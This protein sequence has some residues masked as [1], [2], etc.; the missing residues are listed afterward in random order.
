MT[1]HVM[2]L[3]AA[4]VLARILTQHEEGV[5]SIVL[6]LAIFAF[7]CLHGK[8]TSGLHFTS[9]FSDEFKSSAGGFGMRLTL[10]I[11]TFGHLC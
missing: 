4:V 10:T 7:A 3:R 2:K 1:R 11:S 8:R 5:W 9:C 6:F